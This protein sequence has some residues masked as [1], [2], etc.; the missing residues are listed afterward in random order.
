MNT[1]LKKEKNKIWIK[2]VKGEDKLIAIGND[3]LYKIN[4]KDDKIADFKFDIGNNI[5]SNEVLSIPFSYIKLIK[6]QEGNNYI[7]IFFGSS[8]DGNE[9]HLTVFDVK[10]KQEI[11]DY[12][13]DKIPNSE[14]SFE[15]PSAFQNAYKPMIAVTVVL[16]MFLWTLHLAIQIENGYEY[17]FVSLDGSHTKRGGPIIS[18]ILGIAYFGVTKVL[19]IFLPLLSIGVYKIIK[20]IRNIPSNHLITINK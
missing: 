13:K 16:V 5:I 11:F 3:F 17:E 9:E 1:D 10:K 14:Y 4:P 7:Q 19:A 18:L 20:K 2:D 12:L 6:L 8:K 15:K